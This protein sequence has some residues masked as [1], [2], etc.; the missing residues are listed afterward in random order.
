MKKTAALLLFALSFAP[1]PAL[2]ATTPASPANAA[3]AAP[4]AT[5]TVKTPAFVGNV[6]QGDGV[7]RSR[8]A[9]CHSLIQNKIGPRL[10]GVAGR[11]A[12]ALPDYN[13]SLGLKKSGLV[14]D[15]ATLDHWLA[16]PT[17]LVSNTKMLLNLRNPQ[18]R[19]DVAA[20]LKTIPAPPN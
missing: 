11:K 3:P 16:N 9:M 1:L 12:G 5:E 10:S 17:L 13:Y 18:D 20:Y 15:D 14:W 2:A 4:P 19:A 6:Q 7:F 8:C